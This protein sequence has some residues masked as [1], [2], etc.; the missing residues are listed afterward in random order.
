MSKPDPYMTDAENPELS[1]ADIRAMRPAAEMLGAAFIA[2]QRKGRGPQKAPR[3][4][5]VTLRLD[6]DIVDHFKAAGPG[7]Q[8]AINSALRREVTTAGGGAKGRR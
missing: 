5:Q 6:P 1:T 4:R 7:W 3:K 8:T 2:A